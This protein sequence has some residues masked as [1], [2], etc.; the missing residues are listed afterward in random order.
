[1][2]RRYA[3]LIDELTKGSSMTLAGDDPVA[4][5]RTDD[6]TYYATSDTCTHENWSLGCDG[7]LEGTEVVCPLHMARF[8]VVSGK[9]LCFPA[10]IALR[11]Y[12]VEIVD[13]KVYVVV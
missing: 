9:A 10:A 1:M 7:E 11:S 6:G 8:D 13:D 2:E 3:C 4:L 12:P 5:F